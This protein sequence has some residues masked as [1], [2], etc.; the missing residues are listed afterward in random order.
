MLI[1]SKGQTT[2]GCTICTCCKVWQTQISKDRKEL[3]RL[4][5]D[6]DALIAKIEALLVDL[7]HG[8]SHFGDLEWCRGYE[9][10][11]NR[12]DGNVIV[13]ILRLTPL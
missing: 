1:I 5:L 4:S 7:F 12:L 11:E 2:E 10:L 3:Q 6:S 13:E 8:V 9:H